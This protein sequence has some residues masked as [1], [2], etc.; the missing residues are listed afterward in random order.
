MALEDRK[1]HI[2][3]TIIDDYIATATPV[4]SR[5]IS[6]RPDIA[7]SSATIR[8]EMSDL[9]EMG[10]LD[11]PHTSA[12]RVPS[13]KAYRLYVDQMMRKTDL[14]DNDI[15]SIRQVIDKRIGEAGELIAQTARVLSQLTRYPSVAIAPAAVDAAIRHI[16]LVPVAEGR[17][18][19]V[20]VT[21]AA[22]IHD[23]LMRVPHGFGADELERYSRMLTARLRGHTLGDA[24]ALLETQFGDELRQHR[25]FF[26]QIADALQRNARKV[27]RTPVALGGT[28][29]LFFHPE[30]K[31]LEQARSMISV[32]ETEDIM[33]HLLEPRPQPMQITF[34]IGG[35]NQLDEMKGAS[36][37]T[38]S[39]RIG[40][41]HMA[42]FGVI[43]PTRMDYARV[44]AVL[45]YLGRSLSEIFTARL[46]DE[47]QPFDP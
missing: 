11:Q 43:G 39:Y 37:V 7:L 25:A 23:M 13:D 40:P 30:F 20:V 18:L 31:D 24:T 4:G 35:E 3:R 19:A 8:N 5:A 2:L 33:V 36:I 38:A 47:S 12:G 9:E 10:Y 46:Q 6:K 44:V 45:E 15:R 26:D 21:D 28:S 14:N 22:T 1:W 42:S 34:T 16:Q 27:G 32:L 17:A 41:A 29:N